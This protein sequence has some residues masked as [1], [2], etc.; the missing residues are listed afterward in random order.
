[1]A[2]RSTATSR[3]TWLL[4]REAAHS[5]SA[6]SSTSAVTWRAPRSCGAGRYGPE[7]AVDPPARRLYRRGLILTDG[8]L[9]HRHRRAADRRPGE[10]HHLPGPRRRA[11][12]GWRR[13]SLCRHHQPVGIG[14]RRPRHGGARRGDD[15]RPRVRAV[16]PDRDQHRPRSGTARHRGTPRR[17][18]QAD[19]R[20]RRALHARCPPRRRARAARRRG[21][22]HL[23]ELAG[24]PRRLPR[25]PRGDRRRVPAPFPDGLRILHGRRHR[26]RHAADP[27]RPGRALPHGRRAH[28]RGTAAP[29]STACG[30]AARRRRRAHTAPTGSPRTRCSRRW[31]SRPAPLPTSPSTSSRPS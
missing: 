3:G 22:R 4:S 16:P 1:M 23:A 26:P 6:A 15:R 12:D 19:Q 31:S 27:G 29:R 24:R 8:K 17:R 7:D 5:A 13:P 30:H 2:C 18:R 21:A 11:R 14:R 10:A 20:R 25:L 9:R 28:R